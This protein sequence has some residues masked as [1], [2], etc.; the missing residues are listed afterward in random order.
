MKKII[1]CCA[2]LFFT[3]AGAAQLK[4]TAT[5][6]GYRQEVL[7]GAAKGGIEM[8][9]AEEKSPAKSGTNYFIY[10][11]SDSRVYPSEIWVDGAPYSARVE[12]VKTTPVTNAPSPAVAGE[13]PVVL[14]PKTDRQVVRLTPAP[15]IQEK[16]SARVKSLAGSNAIVVVYKQGGKFFYATLKELKPLQAAAMQ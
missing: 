16:Q 3:L 6:Y 5:L 15:V 1:A 2:L 14:V 8:S 13:A 9:G 4:G 11:V 10:L 7:P 12:L